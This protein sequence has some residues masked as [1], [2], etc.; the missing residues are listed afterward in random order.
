MTNDVCTSNVAL[1]G[2]VFIPRCGTSGIVQVDAA[3]GDTRRIITPPGRAV[4]LDSTPFAAVAYRGDLFAA[5]PTVA[6]QDTNVG[7][8]GRLTDIDPITGAIKKTYDIGGDVSDMT[9]AAGD[10]WVA[11]GT[12]H[13]V[14]RIHLP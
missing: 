10:L 9:V 5:Y 4:G 11:D 1:A 8:A 2:S 13:D 6:D 12:N 7:S 3:T 14:L